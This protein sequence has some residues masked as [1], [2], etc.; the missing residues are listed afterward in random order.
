[1][2]TLP[3]LPPRRGHVTAAR[4]RR[5]PRRPS[6][7]APPCAARRRP[8]APLPPTEPRLP[9]C[10]AALCSLASG[11]RSLTFICC[12]LIPRARQVH[13]PA[14]GS[15]SLDASVSSAGGLS[16]IAGSRC[17]KPARDCPP[18]VRAGREGA[19]SRTD[20]TRRSPDAGPTA[21]ATPRA[22]AD[23]LEQ[24][25]RAAIDEAFPRGRRHARRPLRATH[26][27]CV[28]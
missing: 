26:C 4:A 24:S 1:M 5:R 16:T 2:V 14:G 9:A 17:T 10:A 12:P 20:R 21:P 23:A 22:E 15:P 18:A 25:L 19:G 11:L 27:S 8:P 28:A 13:D 3:R 6:R 7:S